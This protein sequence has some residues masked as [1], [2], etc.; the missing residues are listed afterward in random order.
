MYKKEKDI[1]F[2]ETQLPHE[3]HGLVIGTR[4][5][6]PQL[7]SWADATCGLNNCMLHLW[8]IEIFK[9]LCEVNGSIIPELTGN[10]GFVSIV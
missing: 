7:V 8:V 1:P 10:L 3:V 9:V 2:A 6:S 4:L 5:D